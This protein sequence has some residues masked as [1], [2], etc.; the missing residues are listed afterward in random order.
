M[1][2]GQCYLVMDFEIEPF[3][4]FAIINKYN[5]TPTNC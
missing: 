2:V 3:E 5:P 1:A 4:V